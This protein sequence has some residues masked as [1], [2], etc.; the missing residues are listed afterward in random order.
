MSANQAEQKGLFWT[1]K[2]GNNAD[3]IWASCHV[4]SS[5]AENK[6]TGQLE[7]T[8]IIVDMG[9]NEMPHEFLNGAFQKVVPALDDCLSV[10]GEKKPE[11]EAQ[12]IFLTHSH[13]D[14]IAGIFEYLHMGVKLPEIYASEY[15]I[16]SL[17]KELLDKG[18]KRDQWPEMKTV[19]AGDKIT[20]ND[21]TVEPFTASHS[22]P[23]CFSFKISNGDTS[24]FHSG[25]TKADETSF[26]G[27]GVD[28]SSYDKIGGVELM[29]FDAT[30]T[31]MKG[32][33][34]YEAEIFESYRQL[35]EENPDR[36]VIAV[37]PAAHMERL[38]SVISAAAAAGK[39]VLI[40]GGA[41]M[42]SNILALHLAGY[43][44]QKKCPNVRV[45]SANGD[46]AATIDPD[47][48]VTIT[49]GIYGG[50][51]S[52]FVQKLKG[53]NNDFVMRDNAVVITPSIGQG[54]EQINGLLEEYAPAGVTVITA[55][56]REIYGSGHA[57]A[58]DFVKIAEHV[59]PVTVAPIHC[60][61]KM[62]E[63][64]NVLAKQNGYETLE[65][66]PHNGCTISV[67]KDGCRIVSV[68][69][70]AWF[71]LNHEKQND[72]SIRTSFS[73]EPDH[74]YSKEYDKPSSVHESFLKADQK[75]KNTA[76]QERQEKA[77]KEIKAFHQKKALNK[78][79]ALLKQGKMY[80]R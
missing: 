37:L 14:H 38:A 40:N 32:H 56:D 2:G 54:P 24:I 15:T 26:L 65:K 70:P 20:I 68:R 21:M 23:G 48:S 8:S 13:S 43:D 59:H 60:S 79:I 11:N 4:F 12:A 19:E 47:K 66:R 5:V 27:K 80:D 71:G 7:K 1:P 6:E 46:K 25:D 10:P 16:K 58:D 63:S 49:T 33:A 76:L 41:S 50:G 77:Q 45:V 39:D 75:D 53:E 3:T 18:I 44:L 69:E 17:Q 62:A 55:A 9:Q 28:M 29:T 78:N 34:T 72:G 22:I 35:F 67:T 42:D 61:A 30:A 73:K 31:H 36:Q 57:Q 52:P 51:N 64:F 74:G